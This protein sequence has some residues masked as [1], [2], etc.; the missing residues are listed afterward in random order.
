MVTG[1]A[2]DTVNQRTIQSDIESLDPGS[3]ALTSPWDANI[4]FRADE[5]ANDNDVAYSALTTLVLNLLSESVPMR[6]AV[7][8]AGCGLGYL[9]NSMVTAGYRVVGVD[10][11]RQ[12]IGYA[13]KMFSTIDFYA[14]TLEIHASESQ[15]AERF[16]A[17][18]ANMVMHATP[19]LAAFVASA[20]EMLKPGGSLIATI[21]H[22]CFFL[23]GK[24]FASFDYSKRRGFIIP[25]RIHGGRT[26]PEPVPYFQRT[27][28]DYSD[29]L[30]V[31]GFTNFWIRE[32]QRINNG[33]HDM[34]A[35]SVSRH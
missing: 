9:A 23:P 30:R 34:L 17:V 15:N 33:R 31:A 25:F 10:P 2:G 3:P 6:G 4:D 8:D 21:P 35:I 18:V 13:K 5:L 16:D 1:K 32:P 26:H 29:A 14:E 20:A 19:K 28:Q 7:L 24:D 11:S 27:L 22:P 12:S